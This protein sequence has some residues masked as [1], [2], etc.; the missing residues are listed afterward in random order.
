MVFNNVCLDQSCKPLFHEFMSNRAE[1]L[2][3]QHQHNYDEN[4]RRFRLPSTL[5]RL[6]RL[7]IGST[8]IDA[9]TLRS[10]PYLEH[11]DVSEGICFADEVFKDLRNLKHQ[12]VQGNLP[13]LRQC[14]GVQ[15]LT[16]LTAMWMDCAGT[17]MSLVQE[18]LIKNP[19]LQWVFCSI[20]TS[21]QDPAPFKQDFLRL[22]PGLTVKMVYY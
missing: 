7:D 14:L 18:L 2:I 13:V 19:L 8:S 3:F 16:D 11:L 20:P 9:S 15:T 21:H 10:V 6:K 22:R 5:Y 17:T 4:V 1:E 12:I